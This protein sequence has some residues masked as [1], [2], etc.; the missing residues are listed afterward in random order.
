MTTLLVLL[1]LTVEDS[2]RDEPGRDREKESVSETFKHSFSA[3]NAVSAPIT[4]FS[5]L[6]FIIL[7]SGL[8]ITVKVLEDLLQNRSGPPQSLNGLDRYWRPLARGREVSGA[9]LGPLLLLQNSL[10]VRDES[11]QRASAV[12][13]DFGQG[14][15]A[16]LSEQLEEVQLL[17]DAVVFFRHRLILGDKLVLVDPESEGGGDAEDECEEEGRL[18]D[19]AHLAVAPLRVAVLHHHHRATRACVRGRE[20]ALWGAG[21]GLGRRLRC[22]RLCHVLPDGSGEDLGQRGLERRDGRPREPLRRPQGEGA[23]PH[24]LHVRCRKSSYLSGD[25]HA[26]PHCADLPA[27]DHVTPIDTDQSLFPLHQRASSSSSFCQP[28]AAR[29]RVR[30][31][32]A[33][34]VPRMG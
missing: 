25:I 15:A 12:D 28:W 1:T 19:G 2:P 34:T 23:L 8:L 4:F 21:L 11:P 16:A 24:L 3:V 29:A 18:E 22:R 7:L 30:F 20:A 6:L 13:E 31:F 26:N 27:S 17:A 33:F 32:G 5:R 10:R 9:E 14:P